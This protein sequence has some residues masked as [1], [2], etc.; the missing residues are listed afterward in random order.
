MLREKD[1]KTTTVAKKPVYVIKF[2]ILR[3]FFR[4]ALIGSKTP[5]LKVGR[6]RAGR[7]IRTNT[8]SD[9]DGPL[10]SDEL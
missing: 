2:Q 10:R 3:S 5:M 7:A 4:I 9:G 8:G 6:W 1:N